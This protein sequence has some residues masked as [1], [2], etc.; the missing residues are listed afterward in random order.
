MQTNFC[1]LFKHVIHEVFYFSS[2]HCS[3]MFGTQMEVCNLAARDHKYRGESKYLI[4]LYLI[5][6]IY[7]S[8]IHPL[9]VFTV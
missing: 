3:N 6:Y 1:V 7:V 5:W 4:R 2:S 9:A 8:C